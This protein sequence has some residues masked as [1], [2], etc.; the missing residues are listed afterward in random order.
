MTKTLAAVR[1]IQWLLSQ[2][3]TA[4]FSAIF[5]GAILA[6]LQ[7]VAVKAGWL[8]IPCLLIIFADLVTGIRCARWR[9]EK[10]SMSTALRRTG[11]KILAYFA[12]ILAMAFCDQVY[13]TDLWSYIG[14]GFI[15]LIEGISFFSNVLEP[16]G[17]KLSWRAILRLFGH[18]LN[19]EGLEDVVVKND[20]DPAR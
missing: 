8:L 4:F 3:I 2:P 6:N 20:E 18:K 5:T 13:N 12:W 10:V 1:S 14:V 15:F 16:H 9:K 11:N 19:A 7:E 17:L